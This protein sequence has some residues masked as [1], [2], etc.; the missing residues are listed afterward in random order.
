MSNTLKD[1]NKKLFNQLDRLEGTK[2]EDLDTEIKRGKMV[3][4][5]AREIINNGNLMV[6]IR[7]AIEMD[8]G[9]ST[10]GP[11]IGE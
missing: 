7:S 6:K 5:I 3:A 10:L 4:G 11:L 8:K 2:Q 1:L 9:G